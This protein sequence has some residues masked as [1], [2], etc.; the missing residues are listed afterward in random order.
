MQG[1]SLVDDRAASACVLLGLS[2]GH[3]GDDSYTPNGGGSS[4]SSSSR[5]GEA[6]GSEPRVHPTTVAATIAAAAAAAAAEEEEAP[7][8]SGKRRAQVA[9][10][11]R[12][13]WSLAEDELIRNGVQQLGCRW[14]VIAAQLPGRS[15]DAVRN[16]WSRLQESMRGPGV[17][18][19]PS[20][21]G[22]NGGASSSGD[23]AAVNG[24]GSS[25]AKNGAPVKLERKGSAEKKERTSWTRAEDD[26][27]V[28]GVAELGHKWFEI[29]R[30]LP[31]RTDHAIRN[32]WSRLQSILGLHDAQNSGSAPPTPH[33]LG[34][35]ALCLSRSNSD[36]GGAA[37]S[38]V[39]IGGA[40]GSPRLASA[41]SEG[42]SPRKIREVVS[43]VK[44][45]NGAASSPRLSPAHAL[46]VAE[47]SLARQAHGLSRLSQRAETLADGERPSE[48]RPCAPSPP[49]DR[50][51]CL[52]KS[53]DPLSQSAHP[54]TN[55]TLT[56]Q[57]SSSATVLAHAAP[58]AEAA[59]PRYTHAPPPSPQIAPLAGDAT[60]AAALAERT[61][62]A[63]LLLLHSSP[64]IAPTAQT[65]QPGSAVLP[66]AAQLGLLPPGS[67][68]A[69]L[70]EGSAELMLLKKRP[71]A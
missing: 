19:R 67:R 1:A 65:A 27:I 48:V 62:T 54:M 66:D 34:A 4:S 7:S 55:A 3:S 18:K 37:S 45:E 35:A 31:G 33:E 2:N 56:L 30:R 41:L 28:Q 13:E 20:S 43:A 9:A 11:P 70:P 52:P 53:L 24:E 14:R 71:R 6:A 39:G 49:R 58:H 60:A 51:L 36:L 57:A 59:P 17:P 29:A 63:E 69:S 22:A 44:Q 15:D 50:D 23:S 38:A 46:N 21:G 25:A 8:N 16:R 32:R 12:K 26:V 61:S 47:L 42:S 10:L 64:V 68:V 5:S 40:A